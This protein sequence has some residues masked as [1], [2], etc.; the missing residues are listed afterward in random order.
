MTRYNDI[1]KIDETCKVLCVDN[2]NS[3]DAVVLEFKENDRLTVVLNK[4]I[5]L[6]LSWNG[7]KYHGKGSGLEFLSDGPKIQLIKMR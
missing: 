1:K 2:M 3:V 6:H 4:S 5:K 7:K